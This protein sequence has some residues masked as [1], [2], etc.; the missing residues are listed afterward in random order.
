MTTWRP[1][2][3][4]ASAAGARRPQPGQPSYQPTNRRT[5]V[6]TASSVT[7][8]SSTRYRHT[9]LRCRSSPAPQAHRPETSAQAAEIDA[10]RAA[11]W[12]AHPGYVLIANDGRDWPA[13]ARAAHDLLDGWLATEWRG[14]GR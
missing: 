13:K 9:P 14:T 10:L 3:R 4:W 5:N 2:W 1:R 7:Q 8:R 11:A 6:R 12:H